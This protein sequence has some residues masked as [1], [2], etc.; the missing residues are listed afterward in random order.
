MSSTPVTTEGHDQ[1]DDSPVVQAPRVKIELEDLVHV[2]PGTVCGDYL[3]TFWHPVL[4]ADSLEAGRAKPMRVLGENFTLYRGESG[5]FHSVAYR[6]AHR[7]TLLATGWIEGE[8]I[9][10]RYH[11][12]KYDAQ[13]SCVEQPEEDERFAARIKLRSYPTQEYLGLVFVY[14]GEGAA[15][16]L[17]RYRDFEEEG[18]TVLVKRN[19]YTWP[20]SFFNSLENDE[21]HVNWVHREQLE[22]LG[23]LAA[24]GQLQLS[25]EE[26]DYGLLTHATGWSDPDYV[27]DL[28]FLMPYMRSW[29]SSEGGGF[30]GVASAAIAWR[31]PI[32]DENFTSFGL[33]RISGTREALAA[34]AAKRAAE[35]EDIRDLPT[36]KEVQEAVLRGDMTFETFPGRTH[37]RQFNVG[38]YITQVGLGPFGLLNEENLGRSDIEVA[39]LRRIYRRELKAHAEG[40]PTKAW[41]APERL[42]TCQPSK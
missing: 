30:N 27:Q 10:C 37:G 8:E 35:Q 16:E 19:S 13:G 23:R 33:Q 12:W 3:R 34:Y 9:R 28:M 31:V 36:T 24:P 5:D 2:G 22:E 39:M 17:P 25:V 29:R 26:T 1:R 6:C 4:I 38:D 14:L 40:K 11:G 41:T 21:Y 15:P 42:P 7:G 18:E 20:C 32:D